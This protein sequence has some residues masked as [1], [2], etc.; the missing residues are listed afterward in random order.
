MSPADLN[1]IERRSAQRFPYQV[2]VVLKFPGQTNG[3]GFTQDLSAR[4]AMIWTDFPVSEGQ[5]VEM[6]LVMPAE[7]TL[8]EEMTLR[9][10][11]RVLRRQSLEADRRAA[12][13]L[14]FEHYEFLVGA[15]AAVESAREV[16]LSARHS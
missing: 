7:I 10:R 15:S 11:A 16:E 9:C 6:T 1:R 14:R 13:A 12:I 3:A 4:G 2:P 8:T 5:V